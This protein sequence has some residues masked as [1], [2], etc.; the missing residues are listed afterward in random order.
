[1]IFFTSENRDVLKRSLAGLP[2]TFIQRDGR[3]IKRL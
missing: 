2:H 1:V 3:I